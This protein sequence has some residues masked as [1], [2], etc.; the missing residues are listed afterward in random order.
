MAFLR[1]DL[2]WDKFGG[3]DI[4]FIKKD[5]RPDP[6]VPADQSMWGVDSAKMASILFQ[7]PVM[8]AVHAN[9]MLENLT[10]TV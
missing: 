10:V 6:G 5:V 1:D 3:V 8:V 2:A 9:E 7:K 4:A